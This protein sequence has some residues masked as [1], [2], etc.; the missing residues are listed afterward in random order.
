MAGAAGAPT[1]PIRWRTWRARVAPEV[2]AD[3]QAA[4]AWL[5][6]DGDDRLPI[7]SI[8]GARRQGDGGV[9]FLVREAGAL[10]DRW[11]GE[12]A[13]LS[14]L[15]VAPSRRPA[16]EVQVT[17]AREALAPA[18]FSEW[19]EGLGRR[20][21][22]TAAVEASAS[23]GVA[24]ARCELQRLFFDEY[25]PAARRGLARSVAIEERHDARDQLRHVAAPE[26]QTLFKGS[27]HKDEETGKRRASLEPSQADCDEGR[28]VLDEADVGDDGLDALLDASDARFWR[29]ELGRGL[30]T[31]YAAPQ[32]ALDDAIARTC[33][34]LES[35]ERGGEEGGSLQPMLARDVGA[36]AAAMPV[37][38]ERKER[39][40]AS[41][42]ATR[43]FVR[44]LR[45]IRAQGGCSHLGFT[46]GSKVKGDE[47]LDGAPH[48]ACGVWEGPRLVG[49]ADGL[50]GDNEVDL[51][52]LVPPNAYRAYGCAL[53]ADAEVPDAELTAIVLFLERCC[54]AARVEGA[55]PVH[56]VAAVDSEA[57]LVDVEVA[58]RLEDARA[59][60]PRNRAALLETI[61]TLRKQICERGG[62]VRFIWCPAHVG[63]VGNLA[64]DAVAKAFLYA[65][66]REP[67]LLVRRSLCVF[68]LRESVGVGDGD[69]G[70]GDGGVRAGSSG[71]ALPADR[72][73]FR[74]LRRRLSDASVVERLPEPM[75]KRQ[76]RG[77]QVEAAAAASAGTA[78][79]GDAE[80]EEAEG[81]EEASGHGWLGMWP[82]LDA[83]ALGC[84]R[85]RGDP[86]RWSAVV[87]ATS[88]GSWGGE[89]TRLRSSPTGLRAMMRSDVPLLHGLACCP[90]CG[91]A[92]ARLDLRHV[93]CGECG[94]GAPSDARAE[95][96]ALIEGLLAA[97]ELCLG[98]AGGARPAAA[99]TPVEEA[100]LDAALARELR[101]TARVLR[102]EGGVAPRGSTQAEEEWWRAA[103]LASGMP[104]QLGK[105]ARAAIKAQADKEEE[106]AAPKDKVGVEKARRR[107][108]EKARAVVVAQLDKLAG[109][110]AQHVGA[111][112][113]R[114]EGVGDE[115]GGGG[116][117]GE[118]GA[119]ALDA[120]AA[121]AGAGTVGGGSSGFVG[122]GAV[123]EA[124]AA[125][126]P[127]P[128]P[129]RAKR[130]KRQ[131]AEV[132]EHI[133]VTTASQMAARLEARG[134]KKVKA[135]HAAEVTVGAR[136]LHMVTQLGLVAQRRLRTRGWAADWRAWERRLESEAGPPSG[137]AA[138]AP[139]STDD[140]AA[141]EADAVEASGE[142]DA[143]SEEAAAGSMRRCGGSA[144]RSSTRS[145]RSAT[146]R[147]R[148]RRRRRASSRRARWS[149]AKPT[150]CGLRRSCRR[151]VCG[152]RLRRCRTRASGAPR[153]G[154]CSSASGCGRR[155]RRPSSR[156]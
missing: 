92:G 85:A 41:P 141:P 130:P 29:P 145:V 38:M 87:A 43:R 111:W 58:W 119:A 34:R 127:V 62:S 96:A 102:A 61:C 5:R 150:A 123:A 144:A 2:D 33:V 117:G 17:D 91:M 113:E 4:R 112:R 24:A 22:L 14:R 12:A 75:R 128:A 129:P 39:A 146:P 18:S 23:E 65:Q 88:R 143:A 40:K 131:K 73:P 95:A 50:S 7:V 59:L 70:G 105:S 116:G 13:L 121:G 135:R 56:A 83:D 156:C 80:E 8:S 16:L 122:G 101:L 78:A 149:L 15:E 155:A 93:L 68:T 114:V 140:P 45:A 53:P 1:A 26:Q 103:R 20:D 31:T 11:I 49:D 42:K 47:S 115:G 152:S 86:P 99:S 10:G 64:A 77:S 109:L 104:P 25:V 126:D 19:L 139:A 151:S 9:A 138:A 63:I 54:A 90:L 46:D 67:T 142:E 125:L 153:G 108:L 89:G 154:A 148:P 36:S 37:K 71:P 107:A 3:L 48:T 55:A 134:A 110:L 133:S 118:G 120:A 100:E 97:P 81:A 57:C 82:I 74:L 72:K 60:A 69:G 35:L 98:G 6:R 106:A 51:G 132:A 32:H 27:A 28:A 21:L 76:R 30:D 84:T 137:A 136:P 147:S 52:L 124:A 79:A 94:A 44:L 66:V